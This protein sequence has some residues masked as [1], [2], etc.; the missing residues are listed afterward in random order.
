V[1]LT[2]SI[3]P[4]LVVWESPDG[5][6]AGH[7]Y[8]SSSRENGDPANVSELR[9][10]A[11]IGT[12]VDAPRHFARD[13]DAGIETLRL[14]DLNGPAFVVDVFGVALLDAAVLSDV[15]QH[16]P[17]SV[18]DDIT[19]VVFRTENTKRDLMSQT[20]FHTD[21]VGFTEDGARLIV[22]RFPGIKV[23]GIDYV[24]VAAYEHLI[25]A[26]QFLLEHGIV[27]VEG[28]LVPENLVTPGAW[29]FHCAPIKLEGS[30]GAPARAWVTGPL[31]HY[32]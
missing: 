21:Y 11:H 24:S 26:H 8:Q 4:K 15:F 23:I 3:S 20:D 27:P 6:G 14:E 19:R 7:R 5:L 9:F 28:L 25:P 16:P 18:R 12:H 13:S 29:M 1:D 31:E 22:Q 10:G 2:A 30:D 32:A 17:F